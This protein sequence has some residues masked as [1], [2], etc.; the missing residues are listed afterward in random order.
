MNN[1]ET[2]PWVRKAVIIACVLNIIAL[3]AIILSIIKFSPLT[4]MASVS[5]GGGLLGL[6]ILIYIV[7]V[8]RDLHNEGVL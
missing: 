7:I 3:L 5:I 6:A 4:M 8:V 1:N 2:S